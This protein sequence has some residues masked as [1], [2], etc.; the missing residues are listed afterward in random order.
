VKSLP[1]SLLTRHFLSLLGVALLATAVISWLCVLP[2][3]IRGHVDNPYGGILVFRY[4]DE[5]FHHVLDYTTG[6][7]DR[8]VIHEYTPLIAFGQSQ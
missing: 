8:V 7:Q 4:G 3:Q 1:G 5:V 2:Q 6:D